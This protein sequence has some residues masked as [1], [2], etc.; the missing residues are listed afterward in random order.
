M[1]PR[2]LFF[3]CVTLDIV[4]I[5]LHI[6]LSSSFSIFNLQY[7]RT[8]P[9]YYS[10][11]KLVVLAALSF[12][13]A[14]LV[15]KNKCDTFLWVGISTVFIFLAFDEISELHENITYYLLKYITPL[16]MFKLPTRMWVV[17]YLPFIAGGIGF[18]LTIAKK[19]LQEGKFFFYNIL[20]G[21]LLFCNALVMELLDGMGIASVGMIPLFM[22]EELSEMIGAS[23]FLFTLLLLFIKLFHE[24]YSLKNTL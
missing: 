19:V 22:I 7:E 13:I 8:I 15:K 5:I 12:C 23:I 6:L 18:F 11:L 20:G 10:G 14:L 17:F 2:S 21:L 16:E 1:K 4:L 9:A 24:R 3:F